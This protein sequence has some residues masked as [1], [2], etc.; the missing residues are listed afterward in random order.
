MIAYQT[1]DA[2]CLGNGWNEYSAEEPEKGLVR[3]IH[4][5]K[6]IPETGNYL[7]LRHSARDHA[8]IFVLNSTN[9]IIER[10]S[11]YHSAGLGILAQCSQD[12]KV[13]HFNAVPNPGKNRILSGH[14]D[15][16]HISNC[17][18]L[19]TI[20]N[21]EFRAL[22][23]DPVN[24]HGTS[25][26]II[27]KP[28]SDRLVCQ[29]MHHQSKGMEWARLGDTIG[30]IE[31]QS[32]HTIGRGYVTSFEARNTEIFEIRFSEP[33]PD[34]LNVGDALENLTWTPEALIRNNYFGY[35]RARGLLVSTPGKVLIEGNT[36]E[37][38]GSAIL[39]PGDANYWYESGAVNDVTIRS[40]IFKETCLTSMYQFCEAII[41]ILPEIPIPDRKK[42]AFHKNIRISDNEF[43]PFDY[44]VLYAKSVD[45][46]VF[47]KNIITRS[48]RFIPFHQNQN[49]FKFEFCRNVLIEQNSFADDVPGKNVSLNGMNV[50]DIRIGSGQNLV[51]N[52]K[53][54]EK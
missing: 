16:I 40:N 8:G 47:H 24:I 42:S 5:F 23:D 32:M 29:F 53:A 52:Q 31:N 1:G 28:E 6:R 34:S 33:V 37:S 48:H 4:P 27:E 43:H 35:N 12:I 46:L 11:L 26:R 9:V 17:R 45:D 39:I 10:I 22:M 2:G 50:E 51:I 7:V 3:L 36:F 21:C 44:P 18:G 30:F 38:S 41:S 19:I 13:D 15:G 49:T 14:D 20:Q 54:D 25:V